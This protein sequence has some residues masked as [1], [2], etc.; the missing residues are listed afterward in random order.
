[1]QVS[2]FEIRLT[3]YL[4][5]FG[6]HEASFSPATLGDEIQ[7]AAT[8]ELAGKFELCAHDWQSLKQLVEEHRAAIS[9]FDEEQ[10]KA[11]AFVTGCLNYD[12]GDV[13]TAFRY[14]NMA[15]A[16]R[17]LPASAAAGHLICKRLE[18]A[19][20]LNK[21]RLTTISPEEIESEIADRKVLFSI[22]NEPVRAKT[23]YRALKY[24]DSSRMILSYLLECIQLI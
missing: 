11:Q 8:S 15:A 20:A 18:T 4:V 3:P 10:K 13:S 6:Q 5:Q 24:C 21:T 1:V 7:V 2:I 9:Q 22:G 17:H 19:A 12:Q 14:F 16:S 23:F